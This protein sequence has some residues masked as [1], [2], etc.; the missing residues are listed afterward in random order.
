MAYDIPPDLAGMSLL[1]IAEAVSARKLPPVDQWKPEATSDSHMCIAADGTWY[2]HG[3]PITRPAMVRAFASLLWRDAEDGQHYLVTPQ[4]RQTIEVEDA[5]FI[6]TDL[7]VDAD[8]NGQALAFR[9]NTDELVIA[10]PDHPLRAQGDADAPAIYLAVR[11]G[12]E[13]RLDRSTWLQLAKH[14]L[15]Q[16]DG[17]PAVASRG[18]R[19]SLVPAPPQSS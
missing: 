14:A 2:H 19:F 12:C 15:S 1:E 16:G 8:A 13:A 11:H 7:R 17:E 5:A 6:A 9:L 18:A 4:Y 10:G 3:S